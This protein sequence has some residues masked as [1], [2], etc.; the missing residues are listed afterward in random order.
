MVMKVV[1]TDKLRPID[2]VPP[3]HIRGSQKKRRLKARRNGKVNG[4]G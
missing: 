1:G 2:S 3:D 4:K